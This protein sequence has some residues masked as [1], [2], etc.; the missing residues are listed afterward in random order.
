MDDAM[1]QLYANHSQNPDGFVPPDAPLSQRA[2][3]PNDEQADDA[4]EEALMSE[5]EREAKRA[6]KTPICPVC[7][8]GRA[9][10]VVEL[11]FGVCNL[12]G[13]GADDL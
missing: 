13:Y 4:L 8:S 11:H 6:R 5:E 12:C 2:L 7:T 10:G 3:S 1:S 9:G